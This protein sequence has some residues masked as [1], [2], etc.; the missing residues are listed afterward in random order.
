VHLEDNAPAQVRVELLT[1]DEFQHNGSGPN[2]YCTKAIEKDSARRLSIFLEVTTETG[3]SFAGW[4]KSGGQ[5]NVFRVNTCVDLL[6]GG[7]MT[8]SSH[9]PRRWISTTF[10]RGDGKRKKM[11]KYTEDVSQ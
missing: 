1:A 6:E 7:S 3:T 9:L 8:Q 10:E 4:M 5:R 11:Q 2:I